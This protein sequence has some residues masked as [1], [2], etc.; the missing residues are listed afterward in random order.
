MKQGQAVFIPTPTQGLNKNY[1]VADQP[2]LTSRD[3]VNCRP[4][5]TTTRRQILSA[6]NGMSPYF[7]GALVTAGLK[8]QALAYIPYNARHVTYS[9]DATP[10]EQWGIA[11]VD[12]SVVNRIVAGL[13]DDFF[14]VEANRTLI[15]ANRY[16]AILSRI[17]LPLSTIS[18]AADPGFSDAHTW[19]TVG[20]DEDGAVYVASMLSGGAVG[21]VAER[22]T[23]TGLLKY[24][25]DLADHEKM[26]LQWAIRPD[27]TTG[28]YTVR[29]VGHQGF[30]YA[31]V[32]SLIPNAKSQLWRI[33]NT[34]DADGPVGFDQLVLA[35]LTGAKLSA[36]GLGVLWPGAVVAHDMDVRLNGPLEFVICGAKVEGT[37]TGARFLLK[38]NRAGT[39][40]QFYY[41]ETAAATALHADPN[42]PPVVCGGIGYGC[43]FNSAGDVFSMGPRNSNDNAWFRFI[44]DTGTAWQTASGSYWLRTAAQ[45]LGGAANE[46]LYANPAFCVDPFGNTFVPT[47]KNASG[48]YA[49][50]VFTTTGTVYTSISHMVGSPAAATTNECHST[51]LPSTVPDFFADPITHQLDYK[52]A[53]VAFV[54]GTAV[55]TLTATSASLH[56]YRVLAAAPAVVSPRAI[57]LVGVSGGSLKVFTASGTNSPTNNTARTT[58]L[59]ADARYV[60][61]AEFQGK[62]YFTDGVDYCVY[63]P[64]PTVADPYGTIEN[65]AATTLG[66]IR[67]RARLIAAWNNRLVIGRFPD[68]PFNWQMCA[69]G[70]AGNWDEAPSIDPIATQAIEGNASS[71]GTSPD[72][73]NCLFSYSDDFLIYGGDHSIRILSGDPM[74]GGRI[75]LLSD[76]TGIA[77]GSPICKDPEGRVYFFGSRGGVYAIHPQTR[78]LLWLTRDTIE[79]D[80]ANI[81]LGTNYVRM[82]WNARD[83]GLHVFVM[84]FGNGGTLLTH[85]FWSAKTK[86]W[87]PD[88][89]G[90]ES[91][92]GVQPTASCTIDGD[93]PGDRLMLIGTEDGRVLAWDATANLDDDMSID[94]KALIG[95]FVP[96]ET[97]FETR[98]MDPC[99]VLS[100]AGGGTYVRFFVSDDDS[101]PSQPVAKMKLQP[102]RNEVSMGGCGA[103]C[104]L[105]LRSAT[106]PTDAYGLGQWSVESISVKVATAGRKGQTV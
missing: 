94:S 104:Y 62:L 96:K 69:F 91:S 38:T 12:L 32:N 87:F 24:V 67:P 35:E 48:V 58:P 37:S 103:Y 90:T 31:M 56:G 47:C 26:V 50:R 81:D 106:Q 101:L 70:D 102:G 105:E 34:T 93:L 100:K 68:D 63:D 83:N 30:L 46:P 74:A 10:D 3:I 6:R 73:L 39:L 88:L 80:L 11:T 29:V 82:E 14:Y 13:N 59:S 64:K 15:R 42:T 21:T 45:D 52:I 54:C 2:L 33:K 36:P 27:G 77:F 61:W 53:E 85:Y 40:S 84:P 41:V 1:A 17:D 16:G 92:T 43:R 76:Q 66:I 25:E 4:F 23:E 19:E 18:V 9:A 49:A 60:A 78:E 86:G 55:T 97:E 28:G 5:N 98:F 57:R 8:V 75:G 89:F 44:H 99:V 72:I 95:P 71:A 20:I 65:M 22:Q 51:A 79:A 7:T